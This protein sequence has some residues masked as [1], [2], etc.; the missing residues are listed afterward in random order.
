MQHHFFA[1]L[2]HRPAG[3]YR[4]DAEVGLL[5][6]RGN[7]GAP[8]FMSLSLV[9]PQF[10]AR[11]RQPRAFPDPEADAGAEPEQDQ[12]QFAGGRS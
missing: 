7:D 4:P 1:V 10:K 12:R 11:V 6:R 8:D 9:Q 5:P 2:A 3:R